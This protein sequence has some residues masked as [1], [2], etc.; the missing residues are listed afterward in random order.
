MDG[1]IALAPGAVL[2]L[3]TAT[4]YTLYTIHHEV[5]RGGSCIVYDAS[6]TGNLGN[7]KLVRI[8][9]SYPHVLRIS[10]NK[11]NILEVEARDADAFAAAKE[12]LRSAYQRNHDLFMVN[13]LTNTVA[14]TS[15][16]YEANGTVYI[17]SVY[18]N[19]RTFAEYQGETLHACISLLIG[20]AKVL[21]HI[22]DAG[23]L[24]LDL[25]PDNILTLEGSR[26][27]T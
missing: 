23:Y 18:M 6:Y 15:D 3:E 16:I 20:A 19:G 25:K 4:G 10:R 17:V 2:N 13:G 21:Q 24:Y 11:D 12:R 27:S 14:N 8:K 26:P 1:R 9:E 7:F 5:G 22:H